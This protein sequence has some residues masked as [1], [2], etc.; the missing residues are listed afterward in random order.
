MSLQFHNGAI[1]A[2]MAALGVTCA[3]GPSQRRIGTPEAPPTPVLLTD[4][5]IL[6]TIHTAEDT[7]D[8]LTAAG[9]TLIHDAVTA[10]ILEL[11]AE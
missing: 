9:M 8:R 10:L 4:A 7:A 6:R 11:D 3:G 2:L 1:V 5:P